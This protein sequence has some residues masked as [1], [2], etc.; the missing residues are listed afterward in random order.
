MRN[1]FWLPKKLKAKKCCSKNIKMWSLTQ[2][3][4]LSTTKEL[5]ECHRISDTEQ[6]IGT[7]AIVK[8]WSPWFHF[9][10]ELQSAF[11]ESRI[12]GGLGVH[13][14]CDSYGPIP[15]H[16]GPNMRQ[17]SYTS[18]GFCLRVVAIR[19]GNVG[20]SNVAPLSWLG[21][22]IIIIPD[23]WHPIQWSTPGGWG[24]GPWRGYKKSWEL[25]LRACCMVLLRLWLSSGIGKC[26]RPCIRLCPCGL[27]PFLD[28][29]TLCRFMEELRKR[30]GLRDSKNIIGGEKTMNLCEQG[31]EF[32]L[33]H[34]LCQ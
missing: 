27:S 1:G 11:F 14:Y 7:I 21:H 23:G 2:D 5:H 16:L 18:S 17:W 33:R 30:S 22:A 13:G 29:I 9:P 24:D 34:T 28:L 15:G 20:N 6:F 3:G 12:W 31:W 8:P 32:L 26:K 19:S 4:L 25:F 10:G